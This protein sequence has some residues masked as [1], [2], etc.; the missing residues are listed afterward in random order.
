VV[1]FC[2]PTTKLSISFDKDL[3]EAIRNAAALEQRSVSSW[4]ADAALQRLRLV[5]LGNAVA[6]W[7]ATNGPLTETEIEAADKAFVRAAKRRRPN[8]SKV[9]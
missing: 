2:V 5:A 9:A 6:E 4:I 7:E 1:A 8:S 3:E